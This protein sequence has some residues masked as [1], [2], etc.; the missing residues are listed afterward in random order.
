MTT[1]Q[2]VASRRNRRR[3]CLDR[4]RH[5]HHQRRQKTMDPAMS[6][7]LQLMAII[8]VL[9]GRLPGVPFGLAF[10]TGWREGKP[11]P[12]HND[13]R[14][15]GQRARERGEGSY[16]MR[17]VQSRDV[18]RYRISPSY[19]RLLRDL[20]RP[21]VRARTEALDIL[22]RRL[23]LPQE[24]VGWID[25]QADYGDWGAL[26][27]CIGSRST[28]AEAELAM[29]QAALGWLEART[30][31]DDD[32]PPPP[33]PPGGCA[34]LKPDEAPGGPCGPGTM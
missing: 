20:R 24:A 27:A 6:V 21:Y 11:M 23:A 16:V 7:F 19:R 10:L 30:S 13:E 3:T 1:D 9:F 32:T 18:G 12:N 5:R 34:E 28:D 17:P 31:S 15:A 25:E 29:M 33:P 4:W 26:A 14:D 8:V 22:R 2:M